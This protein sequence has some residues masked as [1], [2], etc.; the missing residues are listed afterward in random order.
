MFISKSLNFLP[1]PMSIPVITLLS[2][3][4]A[5]VTA[6][7]AAVTFTHRDAAGGRP[8]TIYLAA[9]ALWSAGI[10]AE[11]AATSHAWKVFWLNVQY[12]PVVITPVALVAF[13]AEFLGYERWHRRRHLALLATPLL[14]LAVLSWTN[15]A[16]GLVRLGSEIVEYR[17]ESWLVREFGPV[18]W[19]G[20]TYS[21][22]LIVG[23]LAGIGYGIWVS[24]SVFRVQLATVFVGIG[25]PWLAQILLMAE[26]AVIRPEL[27]FSVTGLVFLV[28][29]TRHRLFI[30]S[31]VARRYAV[32]WLPSPVIVTDPSGRVADVNPAA[33]DWFDLTDPIGEEIDSVLSNVP[34]LLSVWESGE[35]PDAPIAVDVGDQTRYVTVRMKSLPELARRDR[36]TVILLQEVTTLQHKQ[37]EL[38]E[39]TDRLETLSHA[40]AHDLR[41]P[42]VIAEGYIDLAREGDDEAIDRVDEALGHMDEIIEQTLSVVDLIE[43]ETNTKPVSIEQAARQ[44]WRAIN[45]RDATLDVISDT[46]VEANPA[47]LQRIFENLFRNALEYAGDDPSVTVAGVDG[48]FVV[49]D[50]G[51]GIP[52][53]ERTAVFRRGYSTEGTGI[54]LSIVKTITRVHGWDVGLAES[55]D[56]GTAFVFG[57]TESLETVAQESGSV[58]EETDLTTIVSGTDVK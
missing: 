25:A 8:A 26:F 16:H 55:T 30:V 23:S 53:D 40:I 15:D 33:R 56:G 52:P 10:A 13:V 39:T 48:G 34:E 29:I 22:V 46:R 49:A 57:A 45:P 54:G 47:G 27:L 35:V 17:G 28:A 51:P 42:L 14:L 5:V 36:G 43:S 1:T 32:E 58:A 31:P 37:Q 19:A 20:W 3:G 41:N 50:D 9:V 2:V 18:W 7:A 6:I 12:I 4:T 38:Q 44:T 24:P 21:Q 11:M